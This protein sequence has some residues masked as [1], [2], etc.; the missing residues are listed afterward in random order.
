[1]AS[2]IGSGMASDTYPP[3]FCRDVPCEVSGRREGVSVREHRGLGSDWLSEEIR[4]ICLLRF[5]WKLY[6][7]RRSRRKARR[8]KI[9]EPIS[10]SCAGDIFPNQWL[11][12]IR[13]ARREDRHLDKFLS[14]TFIM[15]RLVVW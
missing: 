4:E 15:E 13:T 7:S 2:L 12:F 5:L 3:S 8:V 1:M 11:I 10:T 14:S 6:R 9:G